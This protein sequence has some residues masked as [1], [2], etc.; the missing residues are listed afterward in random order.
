MND[1]RAQSKSQAIVGRWRQVAPWDGDDYLSEYTIAFDGNKFSVSAQDLNDGEA[2]QIS[3]VSWDGEA[4]RFRSFMPSTR[5]EG[6]NEFRVL[7]D[8]TIESR[9]TFTVINKLVR[10]ET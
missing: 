10:D 7:S 9:F 5:R 3:D 4:L 6:L 1:G 8:G 2:F